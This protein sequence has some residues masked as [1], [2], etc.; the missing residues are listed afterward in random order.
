MGCLKL[1]II[2]EEFL[3]ECG[4]SV[5][6][7]H[8]I[9]FDKNDSKHCISYDKECEK[10][11]RYSFQG[12]ECDDEIKGSGNSINYKYRMHD[13][14][15]GRFFAVDPLSAIYP[16]NS[17]YSFSEN[18]LIDAIEL[19][20]LESKKLTKLRYFEAGIA[21]GWVAG[22]AFAIQKGTAKDVIGKTYF[23]S[24]SFIVPLRKQ[25]L[26]KGKD[27][28]PVVALEA[29]E[30][31][32]WLNSD[33]NTFYETIN[34]TILTFSGGAFYFG[35]A[36]V[37]GDKIEGEKASL[38]FGA[39]ITI[40][41]TN[42]IIYSYSFDYNEH[43]KLESN[44]IKVTDRSVKKITPILNENKEVTGYRG[45]F[46]FYKN[47]EWCSLN[48]EMTCG[49]IIKTDEDNN[50]SYKPDNQWKSNNYSTKEKLIKTG[51]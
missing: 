32:V 19:E 34:G 6:L 14:R 17:S 45:E 30:G 15:L 11:Y 39:S 10:Y 18:K 12:Q 24:I 37:S 31:F 38:G 23:R 27:A 43:K 20:G 1:H 51:T 16:W 9:A 40:N 44:N 5:P 22:G 25:E 2:E 48:I 36:Y 42:K 3:Q 28:K 29:S 8:N 7:R 26:G 13:P 49:V 46:G 35:G 21:G 41:T 47:G 33:Y 50:D 4:S